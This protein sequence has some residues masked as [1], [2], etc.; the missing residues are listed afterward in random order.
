MAYDLNTLKT[1][2]ENAKYD[3]AYYSI[4]FSEAEKY[5]RDTVPS[6][7][8]TKKIYGKAVEFFSESYDFN[9]YVQDCLLKL[10]EYIVEANLYHH[11]GITYYISIAARNILYDFV[12]K[13]ARRRRVATFNDLSEAETSPYFDNFDDEEEL[14]TAAQ[15]YKAYE[16]GEKKEDEK[17]LQ[18]EKKTYKLVATFNSISEAAKKTGVGRT[19]ISEVLS[20]KRKTAGGFI[21]VK[22]SNPLA[23]MLNV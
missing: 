20:G 4:F 9:D 12:E 13:Q 8:I 19:N 14:F 6:S 21:W 10:W 23:G 22:S 5:I 11:E 15:A 7:P 1:S 18:V 16:P 17:V 3:N 2:F